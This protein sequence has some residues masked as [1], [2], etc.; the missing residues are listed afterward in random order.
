MAEAI[1][2]GGDP[3]LEAKGSLLKGAAFSFAFGLGGVALW[4]LVGGVL[5]IISG[6]VA[7]AIAW[8]NKMGYEKAK[9]PA[10][11]K[12]F[13]VVLIY[14]L[15]VFIGCFLMYWLKFNIAWASEG[16]CSLAEV[17]PNIV[18][19]AEPLMED[20]FI[21]GLFALIGLVFLFLNTEK[22]QAKFQE[23]QQKQIEKRQA[24]MEAQKA[25]RDAKKG[26]IAEKPVEEIVIE[27]TDE[28]K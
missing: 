2:T 15:Q 6:W 24:M 21:I 5:G 11:A 25:K 14:L 13:V 4:V 22:M 1:I 9:G 28:K 3:T 17:W 16:G 23:S 8:L 12:Y 20:F 7:F 26:K 18:Y 10:K 27:K 19:N